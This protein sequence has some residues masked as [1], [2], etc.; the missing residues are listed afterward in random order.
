MEEYEGG[1]PDERRAPRPVYL[2]GSYR[3]EK[4]DTIYLRRTAIAYRSRSST[5]DT[6]VRVRTYTTDGCKRQSRSFVRLSGFRGEGDGTAL[7]VVSLTYETGGWD[8]GGG[9]RKGFIN[10]IIAPYGRN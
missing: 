1:G 10:V 3:T 4:I 9:N 5:V 8:G 7:I 2:R 6:R